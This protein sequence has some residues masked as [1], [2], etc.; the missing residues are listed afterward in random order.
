MATITTNT[1]KK[2]RDFF[3]QN[4]K[5]ALELYAAN[6]KAIDFIAKNFPTLLLSI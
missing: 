4:Q 2:E 3:N 1:K 5:K 6:K